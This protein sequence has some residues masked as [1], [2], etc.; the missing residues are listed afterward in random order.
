MSRSV[1]SRKRGAPRGPPQPHPSKRP[2]RGAAPPPPPRFLERVFTPA[3]RAAAA[4]RGRAWS[5]SLAGRFAAKEAVLKALGTGLRYGKWREV[6]VVRD[7]AGRPVLAL[8]GRL[9]EVAARRGAVR[10]HLT[11]SHTRH[12]AVAC[13]VAEGRGEDGGQPWSA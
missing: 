10:W 4:R 13:A 3:E 11:I 7:V 1:A 6:E 9:A 12:Y 5:Q 8:K 2:A